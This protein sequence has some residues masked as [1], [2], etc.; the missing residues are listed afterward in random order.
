MGRGEE[1]RELYADNNLY[2]MTRDAFVGLIP[3]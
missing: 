1:R 3:T 2:D